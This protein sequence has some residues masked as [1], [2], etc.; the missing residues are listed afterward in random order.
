MAA[1]ILVRTSPGIAAEYITAFVAEADL[2]RAGGTHGLAEEHEDI[3]VLVVPLEA[4]MAALAAGEVRNAPLMLS[5]F[6][7]DRNAA[8]LR[9]AWT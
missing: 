3:R 8:R 6:W 4:A 1:V 5:L 9:A 7:L 2:G